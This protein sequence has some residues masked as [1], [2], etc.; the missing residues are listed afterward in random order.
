MRIVE[1]ATSVGSIDDIPT[2]ATNAASNAS[3]TGAA[4]RHRSP[5]P[6]GVLAPLLSRPPS[7]RE[8]TCS[9]PAPQ[10]P[11]SSH[12]FAAFL[13]DDQ[14]AWHESGTPDQI[15]SA[16]RA[17]VEE[18]IRRSKLD[19]VFLSLGCNS[20]T[21]PPPLATVRPPHVTHQAT[22][23]SMHEPHDASAPRQTSEI[24]PEQADLERAGQADNNNRL[25]EFLDARGF[26]LVPSPS[27][28]HNCSIYSLVQQIRPALSGAR[29]DAEVAAIRALYDNACGAD[30]ARA[31]DRG[32]MLHF[33]AHRGGAAPLLL[34]IVNRRYGCNVEVGVI[35]AGVDAHPLAHCGAIRSPASSALDTVTHRI[36]VCNLLGHYEAVGMK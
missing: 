9:S 31:N 34:D 14:L 33:D 3:Q 8:S 22:P 19:H 13:S 25:R 23:A 16:D 20:Q 11:G 15:D 30:P 21:A 4:V 26:E 27:K 5:A 6:T 36:V 10:K 29:L 18:A 1:N 35:I 7:R 24:S 12:R 2:N 28:G 32:N 17:A